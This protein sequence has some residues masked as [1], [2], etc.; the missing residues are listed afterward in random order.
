M[1]QTALAGTALLPPGALRDIPPRDCRGGSYVVPTMQEL[2][3]QPCG[4][5]NTAF[6]HIL[7]LHFFTGVPC[8][9]SFT[10]NGIT[11][12]RHYTLPCWHSGRTT[13]SR[14]QDRKRLSRLRQLLVRVWRLVT[15]LHDP[16][17]DHS[18]APDT[19]TIVSGFLNEDR[20]QWW[21]VALLCDSCFQEHAGMSISDFTS[22]VSDA[23]IRG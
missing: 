6:P 11:R 8:P 9:G 4:T 14:D 19:G 13:E 18:F 1:S 17:H 21:Q 2:G 3:R 20:V 15:R 22:Q 12:V 23:Q 5:D 16:S 10:H 7:A